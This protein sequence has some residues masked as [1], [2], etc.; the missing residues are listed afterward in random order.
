MF[1]ILLFC[2][3]ISD[4]LL[5]ISL[6][7]SKLFGDILDLVLNRDL[8]KGVIHSGSRED[9]LIVFKS[10]TFIQSDQLFNTKI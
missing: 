9:I 3:I 2:R 7:R 6:F 1:N 5:L 10:H 4:I 8:S